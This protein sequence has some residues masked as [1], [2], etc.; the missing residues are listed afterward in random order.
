MTDQ[1]DREDDQQAEHDEDQPDED[2]GLAASLE[3]VP[4]VFPS[5]EIPVPPS[6]ADA[7]AP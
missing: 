1:P 5:G 3:D 2:D 7:P 4:K 6:E